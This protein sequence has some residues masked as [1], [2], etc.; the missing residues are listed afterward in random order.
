[1][2]DRGYPMMSDD[3]STQTQIRPDFKAEKPVRLRFDP[4]AEEL[5]TPFRKRAIEKVFEFA[6][7]ELGSALESAVV[8]V[9]NDH[10]EPAPPTLILSFVADIDGSEWSR[11]FRAILKAEHEMESSWPDEKRLD[12][13]RNVYVSLMPLRI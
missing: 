3:R 4:E 13:R 2:P 12:W 6:C 5:L 8:L 7:R 10:W 1:M 9:D 11:T